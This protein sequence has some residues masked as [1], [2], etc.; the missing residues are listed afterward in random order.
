[1]ADGTGG[2]GAGGPPG[3]PP[4]P[5][6]DRDVVIGYLFDPD[7]SDLLAELEGGPLL[8]ADLAKKAGI[9]PADVDSRLSYL[10]EHG[11]VA[12]R[13]DPS[14]G[15]VSY[16]ADPSRLA[17]VMEHDENYRTAVDGLAKLDSFLN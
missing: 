16:E 10:A 3:A 17:A 6:G 8:L 7:V 13:T 12:R 11:Y 9:A 4:P 15:A 1:M 14:T 5:P 2:A